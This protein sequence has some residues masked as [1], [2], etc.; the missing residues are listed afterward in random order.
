MQSASNV[1]KKQKIPL[2]IL[3]AK[4]PKELLDTISNENFH[5]IIAEKTSEAIN[6]LNKSQFFVVVA[7]LGIK[8]DYS[9]HC[10]PLIEAIRKKNKSTF[11]IIFS[12]TATNSAKAREE[13]FNQGA[14]MVTNCLIS[15]RNVLKQINSIFFSPLLGTLICPICLLSNLTEDSLWLHLPLYH[16]NE[17]NLKTNCP[18]CQSITDPN[19]Q[20]HFRNAHG[21]CGRK[22]I[23]K[24]HRNDMYLYAFSLVVVHR[25]KDNKFLLVQEFANSG[26]WLPGGGVDL[27]EDLMEAGIR[28][29]KE[30][31]G[32]DIKITGVLT[33]QYSSD[34]YVRLRTIFYGEPIDE[35][36]KP[37][38]IPDYESVG[39]AYVS[40][41]E[42]E[43]LSLRG[44]EPLIWIGYVLNGKEIFSTSIFSSEHG[45]SIKKK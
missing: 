30:E 14:N 2:L 32:I 7:A 4:P 17:R 21:P 33:F 6:E 35:N 13:C 40:F 11:I 10:K 16:I 36:Q 41:E 19:L 8:E 39:A 24:D 43:K 27:G 26:Y 15:L 37:K 1:S 5:P 28:E 22:E 31:A 29:T 42:I 25:K 3:K 34:K 45:N 38:S 12:H 20:V 9:D 44:E 18:L 23:P